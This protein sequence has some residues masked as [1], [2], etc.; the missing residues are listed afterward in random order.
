[1]S[2]GDALVPKN[3]HVLVFMWNILICVTFNQT[4][5]ECI[6]ESWLSYCAVCMITITVKNK[7]NIL[8][9]MGQIVRWAASALRRKRSA[10][11]QTLPGSQYGRIFMAPKIF[12]GG[13]IQ[14][15]DIDQVENIIFWSCYSWRPFEYLMHW[16]FDVLIPQIDIK[17][18]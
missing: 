7:S 12:M 14:F 3:G 8:Y 5:P 9:Y 13:T 11:N 6:I 4:S 1:M 15:D 10:W 18:I 17:S 2:A 16:C